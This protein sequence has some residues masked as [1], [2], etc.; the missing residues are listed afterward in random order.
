LRRAEGTR[1]DTT[2]A[3]SKFAGAADIAPVD[4][5][6]FPRIR[7]D[8][9][10]AASP[11]NVPVFATQQCEVMHEQLIVSSV[12]FFTRRAAVHACPPGRVFP[13]RKRTSTV[14]WRVLWPGASQ[15]CASSRR[16]SALELYMQSEGS[17]GNIS[18]VR[19]SLLAGGDVGRCADAAP[20]ER[21]ATSVPGQLEASVVWTRDSRYFPGTRGQI[22]RK[23]RELVFRSA[24]KTKRGPSA[25][26]S[27]RA[28][29]PSGSASL[30]AGSP[31]D[32]AAG[33]AGS[34]LPTAQ[35]DTPRLPPRAPP[36]APPPR[37]GR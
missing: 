7:N 26:F 11:Y 36:D 23:W 6:C 17:A 24:P 27:A 12:V 37:A 10:T 22:P 14:G 35:R 32:A 34:A 31:G 1:D 33:R 30:H 13:V 4:A 20:G 25:P 9:N 18:R 8:L 2:D 3:P 16:V 5:R 29:A 28:R 21:P 19:Q 15:C